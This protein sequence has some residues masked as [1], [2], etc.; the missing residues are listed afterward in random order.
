MATL[1]QLLMHATPKTCVNL[2]QTFHLLTPIIFPRSLQLAPA[3]LA[4]RGCLP[5]GARRSPSVFRYLY[6]LTPSANA[7]C[8]RTPKGDQPR[9]VAVIMAN[10]EGAKARE[11]Y[12][13][14]Y[15][16]GFPSE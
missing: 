7:R 15:V 3:A 6:W 13:D 12:Q 16:E 14:F 1:S 8:C 10:P 4:R 5:L 2:N 11:P 9:V